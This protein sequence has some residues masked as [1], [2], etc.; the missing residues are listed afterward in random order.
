MTVS[1]RIVIF[2]AGGHAKVVAEIATAL[3][4]EVAAFLEDG[5]HDGEFFQDCADHLMA[6]VR[7]ESGAG[8]RAPGSRRLSATT[9]CERKS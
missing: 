5:E 4:S 1:Q 6:E 9:Q 8:G 2:G 7:H 3:G